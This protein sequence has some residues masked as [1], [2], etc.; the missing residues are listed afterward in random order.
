[1]LQPSYLLPKGSH[2]PQSSWSWTVE[3]Y[4]EIGGKHGGLDHEV[5][6][7]VKHYMN[8]KA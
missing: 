4:K 1:M 3:P 5:D 7:P 2:I 6:D 8:K